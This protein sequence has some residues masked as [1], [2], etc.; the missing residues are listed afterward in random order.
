MPCVLSTWSEDAKVLDL[1][2]NNSLRWCSTN[3]HAPC[4]LCCAFEPHT[5]RM[6]VWS[7]SPGSL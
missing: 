1:F 5:N 6:S 7:A 2:N 3:S 4:C